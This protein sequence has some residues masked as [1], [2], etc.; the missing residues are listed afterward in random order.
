MVAHNAYRQRGGEDA[1]VDSEIT[2]LRSHGHEVIE[3]R[4]HNDEVQDV[5]K[6]HLA[7]ET[8]W[9]RRTVAEVEKLLGVHRPQLIHVHNTLPLISPSI[10]WAAA[11]AGLPVVQTLHN[12]RLICPQAMLLRQGRVCEKCVGAS[13]LPAVVHGCYRN[14]RAQSAVLAGMLSVHR[15]LGTWSQKIDRYIALNEFC[16]DKFIQGGLPAERIAVKPNFVHEPPARQQNQPR[17]GLLF[18]GRLA[19]EKGIELL[20]QAAANMAEGVLRIAG[21]GPSDVAIRSLRSVQML[22]ELER[23]RVTSEMASA[24]ALVM[25]SLCYE[26]F[27]LALVE[28]FSC[29]LPVLASRLGALAT[30]VEDG[31]TGL[32]FEA[33]SS[34][35]LEAKMQWAL[36]HPERMAEMGLAARKAYEELYS[37]E[38]N[39]RQLSAV[40]RS[41]ISSRAG[42]R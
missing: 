38:V 35:D 27:P 6:V 40:Y 32:L 10:Y 24:I 29:G 8:L 7:G 39:Y 37:P 41:V 28:A 14:S 33:G 19:P 13:T 11:S 34:S 26:N 42:D 22:G 18:V 12:F 31:V 15:A 21:A 5:G 30:L 16:R 9:S 20:A 36:A 3:Y 17:S 1:V 4:R 23:G 2:L 25:P